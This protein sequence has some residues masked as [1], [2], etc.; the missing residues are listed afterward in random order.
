MVHAALTPFDV[1]PG[2]VSSSG[3]FDLLT[4]ATGVGGELVAVTGR[5]HVMTQVSFNGDGT[6]EIAV[7]TNL[8][9][10]TGTGISTGLSYV[11]VGSDFQRFLIPGNPVLPPYLAT[12]QL[13]PT[14]PH[15]PTDPHIPGNPV[16]PISLTLSL[17]FD[18]AGRL[19]GGGGG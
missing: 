7:E 14:D 19:L 4:L 17:F 9:A 5:L 2:T 12:Y 8:V 18:A 10:G 11:A 13:H 15:F 3:L 1:F 16:F 6:T